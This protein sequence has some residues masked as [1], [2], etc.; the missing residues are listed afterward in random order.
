MNVSKT[1]MRRRTGYAARKCLA[2]AVVISAT[3]AAAHLGPASAR[4]KCWPTVTTDQN[5]SFV[6]A[7]IES[8]DARSI[9]ASQCIL[10][11]EHKGF[12]WATLATQSEFGGACYFVPA[13]TPDANHFQVRF[14]GDRFHSSAISAEFYIAVGAVQTDNS[15]SSSI[16][17]DLLPIRVMQLNDKPGSDNAC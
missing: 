13:F 12:N 16:F 4:S 11:E 3:P 10:L 8:C 14:S 2:I 6:T 15:A 9:E 5:P 7:H 1:F 17:S